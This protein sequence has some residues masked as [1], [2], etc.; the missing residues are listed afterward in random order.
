VPGSIW[1]VYNVLYILGAGFSAPLGLP[2]ISNFLFMA[3]DMM[4]LEP[5]RY[6]YFRSVLDQARS[7]STAKNY[8]SADLFNIEHVLSI[9]EMRSHTR[10]EKLPKEFI[11]FLADVVEYYTPNEPMS[12]L[13]P[14]ALPQNRNDLCAVSAIDHPLWSAYISFLAC[15]F[16]L[17]VWN[18]ET[19]GKG[20]S[21]QAIY[22][23]SHYKYG[24]LSLN[25][26]EVLEK[27]L[28]FIQK[29]PGMDHCP[30]YYISSGRSGSYLKDVNKVSL[31][32]LHGTV[33]K[34]RI[35]APTWNKTHD[36]GTRKVW[37]LAE[38]QLKRATFIRFLGYSL[39]ESDSYF[40]YLL[41]AALTDNEALRGIDVVCLDPDGAVRSR[42]ERI[43]SFRPLNFVSANLTE[44]LSLI[45]DGFTGAVDLARD[46]RRMDTDMERGHREFLRHHG[47]SETVPFQPMNH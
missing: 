7:L 29:W 24:F 6:Q 17:E 12:S 47:V 45:K 27:S 8:L 41:A 1:P 42:Y 26:D 38:E 20:K 39:P 5:K 21:A 9:I 34:R 43:I 46:N 10:N 44:Y 33:T 37:A 16:C 28:S 35:V 2:V 31:A 23:D 22:P 4:E 40:Q 19:D 11:R 25:Y 30:P 36:T 14:I 3:R 13:G 15:A 18:T 32:K